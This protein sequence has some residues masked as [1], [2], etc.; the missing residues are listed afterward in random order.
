M[1][2]MSAVSVLAPTP[3]INPRTFTDSAHHHTLTRRAKTMPPDH[4][5]PPR[6]T[7]RLRRAALLLAHSGAAASAKVELDALARRLMETGLIDSVGLAFSEHGSPSLREA[8]RSLADKKVD[9][10]LLLPLPM[11]M[12]PSLRLWIARAVQRWRAAA[13]GLHWPTV[14]LAPGPAETSA[15]KEVLREMLTAAEEAPL[16]GEQ[17]LFASDASL[18][19]AQHWR[20]LVCQGPACNSAG[21]PAAWSRL[22]QDQE[23]L[24]LRT[25]HLGVV[26]C[27]TSC[28]GPC[29]LAPVLQVYPG[30]QVYGGVDEAGVGRIVQEH[31]I[32]GAV[33]PELAYA[34]TARKQR[35]RPIDRRPTAA[36]MDEQ[37]AADDTAADSGAPAVLRR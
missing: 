29:S 33:V 20:V 23:R 8:L 1:I 9:E 26:S 36:V 27:T 16:L 31:L 5:L 7:A 10:V 14:R 34:P 28:L 13:P 4:S 6:C 35:L 30:G 17:A 18:V 12:A 15:I 32:G 21:A 19:P 37:A 2:S 3:S 24:D 22:M 11:P 25:R